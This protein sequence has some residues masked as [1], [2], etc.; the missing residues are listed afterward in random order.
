MVSRT[1]PQAALMAFVRERHHVGAG[2]GVDDAVGASGGQV[3]GSNQAVG[4][5]SGKTPGCVCDDLYVCD[6]ANPPLVD[7]M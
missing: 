3:V 1:L 7:G 5:G 4:R 6:V 2:Q